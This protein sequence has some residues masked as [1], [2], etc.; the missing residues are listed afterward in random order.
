MQSKLR[1]KHEHQYAGPAIRAQEKNAPSHSLMLM[2]IGSP[3]YLPSSFGVI[4]V[5]AFYGDFD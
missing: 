5:S 3:N 4:I 2:V 1:I